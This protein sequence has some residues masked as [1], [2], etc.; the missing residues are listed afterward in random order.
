VTWIDLV[1]VFLVQFPG[2]PTPEKQSIAITIET[3]E[4]KRNMQKTRDDAVVVWFANSEEIKIKIYY[5]E[6]TWRIDMLNHIDNEIKRRLKDEFALIRRLRSILS[7]LFALSIPVFLIVIAIMSMVFVDSYSNAERDSFMSSIMNESNFQA[8]VVK[9][10]DYLIRSNSTIMNPFMD[11]KLWIYI[12]ASLLICL[13]LLLF[14]FTQPRSYLLLNSAS[15]ARK[16]TLERR[17]ERLKTSAVGVVFLGVI[18]EVLGARI[19]DL[20]KM[21]L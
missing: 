18:A 17:R 12:L 1:W 8:E 19:S 4:T 21:I 5:I 6:L 11:L 2:R 7:L 9:R 20:I 16:M 10:L 3:G 13:S 15:E 14:S